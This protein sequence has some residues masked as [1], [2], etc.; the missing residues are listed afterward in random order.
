MC[1]QQTRKS[2]SS[3]VHLLKIDFSFFICQKYFCNNFNS[4]NDYGFFREIGM[5]REA[6]LYK[7][8]GLK[9]TASQD[10]IK[11]AF[12]K[13][14]LKY[15]PDKVITLLFLRNIYDYV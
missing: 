8:L 7:T 14:A 6:K 2:N 13:L 9:S 4:L 5:V 15:H 11:K 12:R 3:R 10:E 1:L